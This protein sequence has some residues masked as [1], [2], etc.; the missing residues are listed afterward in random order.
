MPSSS[1]KMRPRWEWRTFDASL[2]WLE[3]KIGLSVQIERK[4][5]RE[6]YLLHSKSPHSAK[7]RNRRL[8]VKR[9]EKVDAAGLELWNPAFNAG[10]PMPASLLQEAFVALG[11]AP[12]VVERNQYSMEEFL[13]EII[14][15]DKAFRSVQVLMARRQFVYGAC[16]AELVRIRIGT[17]L[18]DSFCIEDEKPQKVMA[19]LGE[20]RL[21]SK[22]NINFPK[23][24][25]RALGSDQ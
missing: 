22:S 11:L 23:G 25:T 5:S 7:I 1:T 14:D 12:P 4:Q 9:R 15:R 2:A 21:D 20:L 13:T 10:F 16:A 18:Q 3:A 24:L 17:I 19:A 8:D 6:I